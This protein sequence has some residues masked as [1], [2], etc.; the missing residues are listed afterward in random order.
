MVKLPLKSSDLNRG[1][2]GRGCHVDVTNIRS[3]VIVVTIGD[4]SMG[5]MLI[6][7]VLLDKLLEKS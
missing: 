4:D 2:C 6:K 5:N 7:N 1:R 3:M